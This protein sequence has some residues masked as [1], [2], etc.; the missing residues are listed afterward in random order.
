MYIHKKGRGNLMPSINDSMVILER[1][2]I[3]YYVYNLSTIKKIALNNKINKCDYNMINE[4]VHAVVRYCELS[5]YLILLH[6]LIIM[7]YILSTP[8]C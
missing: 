6:N 2:F 7:S 4:I 8:G 1:V 5:T 3:A